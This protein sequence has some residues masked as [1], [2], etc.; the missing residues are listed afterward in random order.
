VLIVT[1]P[2]PLQGT[3]FKRIEVIRRPEQAKSTLIFPGVT[4]CTLV[5]S[6]A[7]AG[8]LFTG[9]LTIEPGGCYPFYSRPFTESLTLLEGDAVVDAETHRYRLGVLDSATLPRRMPRRIV[10]LS[11]T[12]PAVFH[13]ALA[14]NSAVSTWVN[15]RFEPVEQSLASHGREK[16]ERISRN[17]P[18]ASYEL[19]P[20]AQLQDLY[21]SELGSS[22]ICG[23]IC[24]FGAGARLPCHRVEFDESVTIILG[25]ATCIVEGRR[26][27]LTC[28][29]A[30][31][32]PRG[33]CHYFINLTLEPMAM[34]WVYS[35][36]RPDRG[37]VDES[38]CHPD[39]VGAGRVSARGDRR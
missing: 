27:E 8:D 37:I 32:V 7:G 6:E 14:A 15:A 38:L 9:M 19:M 20:R 3:R 18:E 33:L 36:D 5:D 30:V 1:T 13:V 25:T 4:L 22:D 17:N 29:A 2:T 24:H 16:G 39:R 23:G 31:F 21:G 34:V 28:H 26:H 11:A 35:G 10:N 12:E